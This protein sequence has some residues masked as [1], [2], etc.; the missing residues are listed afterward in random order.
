MAHLFC[1]IHARLASI[2]LVSEG[3][4]TLPLTQKELPD[5]LGLSPVHVNRTLQALRVSNMLAIKRSAIE[6]LDLPRLKAYADFNSNYL[7]LSKL[8]S[9]QE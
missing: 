6:I 1:E 3:K 2:G 7:H 4:F 8:Q 5:T 9:A